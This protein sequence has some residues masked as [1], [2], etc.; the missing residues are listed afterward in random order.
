MPA[1]LLLLCGGT[2]YGETITHFYTVTVDYSL[3]T[4]WVEAR[5]SRPVMSVTARSRDAGRFLTDVRG[6]HQDQ[7]I[8]LR[9]RRMMLPEHGI[10]CLNYTVDLERVAKENRNSRLLL[11]G[12]IIASPSYWLWRPELH[13]GTQMQVEFRLPE[14]VQVSVPWQQAINSTTT[15]LLTQSPESASAPAVFGDFDY[16]EI[17]I[18]GALLRVSML[19]GINA[20]DNDAIA[21]WVEATATD[22][23][24]AYGR[25]PNPSP[26]IVVVAVGDGRANSR[27][28]VPFGRVIRDGGETVELFVDQTQPLHALLADW[29]ATHEFSHMLL[30][31]VER[32]QRWI[33]EG[34][35]QY[36]QNV[37]LARSGA[38]EDLY[39]WQKL[40]DGFERGRK[41]RPELSP[42]E[43]AAGDFRSGLMKVYWSGAALAL[44][45]DVA[46]RERSGGT[47]SLDTVLSAFQECCLPSNRVWSGTELFAKF[48]LLAGEALF[49]PLYRRYA[50]T[51]GFP[52]LS[53]VF[54]TLGIALDDG[55]VRM[56]RNGELRHVREAI[57]ETDVDAANLRQQ[58]AANE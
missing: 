42:N 14:N 19:N 11:S 55:K 15:Y 27:S 7:D 48:D 28:A 31:Y 54:A 17:P 16:R 8:R 9:N 50:D 25:F 43:A 23:T 49:M 20:M 22:V 51:A 41:S 29:T 44:M 35:S 2:A 6:C 56:K 13:N 46:L 32:R 36:Y 21:D 30:P 38:Y 5:F 53:P 57:T 52:D 40:Y 12:N 10:E 58:I 18:P 24:F 33:S 39:A 34:F 1:L 45:A 37:L 4:L 47:Q 3:S 26:Q